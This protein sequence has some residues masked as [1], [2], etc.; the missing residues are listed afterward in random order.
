MTAVKILGKEY[1]LKGDPDPE[2]MQHVADYVDQLLH[3]IGRT[4]PDTLDAAI[5]AVINIASE[6]LR[7]RDSGCVVE[8]ERIRALI[9]LVDSV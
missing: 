7:I 1:R 5:L 3:E 6:F 9:D 8:G 2:H 4:H